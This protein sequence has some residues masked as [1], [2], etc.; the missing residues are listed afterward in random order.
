MKLTIVIVN[1]NSVNYLRGCL[2]AVYA[3]TRDVEFEVI[4]VDNGS[5]D[6][7]AALISNEFQCVRF[8]Q[9]TLNLGFARANNLAVAEAEGEFLLFLNPDTIP[10]NGSIDSLVTS[11]QSLPTAGTAGARILNADGSLQTSCIQAYPTMMNQLLDSQLLRR[12]VPR[13]DLWGTAPLFAK[14]R[15]PTPVEAISGACLLTR[16]PIFEELG[17]FSTDFF[18]YYEDIEYCY[19]VARAGWKNY[20]VPDAVVIHYGGKSCESSSAVLPSI[21]MAESACRFFEKSHGR[22]SA[23]V[24]QAGL[25][26]KA[27]QRAAAYAVSLLLWPSRRHKARARQAYRRWIGVFRHCL[28]RHGGVVNTRSRVGGTESFQDALAGG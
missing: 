18:M 19:R 9:G 17:G 1:W 8:L 10:V 16:K 21:W 26:L 14:L 12:T 4:V 11:I 7:C 20:Y 22:Y 5:Y 15:R 25:A 24:F 13:A 3:T 28:S 27:I 23:R 6:G 2:A